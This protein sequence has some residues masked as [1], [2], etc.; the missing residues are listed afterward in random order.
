MLTQRAFR[1]RLTFRVSSRVLDCTGGCAFNT[2]V[3]VK[4]CLLGPSMAGDYHVVVHAGPQSKEQHTPIARKTNEP[5]WD[6]SLDFASPL[7]PTALYG[8]LVKQRRTVVRTPPVV[9]T[10][11]SLLMLPRGS[12]PV[13]MHGVSP[14]FLPPR[15]TPPPY[16]STITF[17][18]IYQP[19]S[20]TFSRLLSCTLISPAATLHRAVQVGTFRLDIRGLGGAEGVVGV[21]CGTTHKRVLVTR[22]DDERDILGALDM[23]IQVVSLRGREVDLRQSLVAV[24]A[25]MAAGAI[26][27]N[28]SLPFYTVVSVHVFAAR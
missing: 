16:A 15:C 19:L 7:P 3:V 25:S 1:G 4:Q 14:R 11:G 22:I 27:H 21:R 23:G 18:G 6:S 10:L 28:P 12:R 9:A 24:R 2:R 13:H 26:P 17:P 20:H 8:Y 5:Q